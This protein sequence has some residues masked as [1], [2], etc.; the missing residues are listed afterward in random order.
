MLVLGCMLYLVVAGDVVQV[1]SFAVK[2]IVVIVSMEYFVAG[3]SC[4]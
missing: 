3:Y 4:T 2:C 1:G